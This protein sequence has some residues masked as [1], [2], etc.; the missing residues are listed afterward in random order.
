[1]D[2]QADAAHAGGEQAEADRAL[3]A[4]IRARR[5]SRGATLVS[6]AGATG[7][8]HSFLSQVERGLARPSMRSLFQ[9]AEALATTQQ[10][11]MGAGRGAG[12]PLVRGRDAPSVRVVR[13][14]GAG[15]GGGPGVGGGR[16]DGGARLVLRTEGVDVTEFV[17]PPRD[18]RDL[19]SHEHPESLYVAAGPPGSTSSSSTVPARLLVLEARDT[20]SYP[21]GTAH[22]FRQVGEATAVVLVL[23]PRPDHVSG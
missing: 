2:E 12:E 17:G 7:L 1:M 18:F 3:G 14:G 5:R 15:S 6:V 20:A 23:H 4:A 19:F 22:R 9:I 8:S 11:L 21:G 13:A 16:G 10:E